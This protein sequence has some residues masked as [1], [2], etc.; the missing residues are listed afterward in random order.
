MK[1]DMHLLAF[2]QQSTIKNQQ[3]GALPARYFGAVKDIVL[4]SNGALFAKLRYPQ[5]V[6]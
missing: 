3:F 1:F 4:T 2:I 5:K 6:R